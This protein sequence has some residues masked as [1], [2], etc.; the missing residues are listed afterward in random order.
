MKA[1][2]VP[3]VTG[4][5]T[6]VWIAEQRLGRSPLCW[7]GRKEQSRQRVQGVAGQSWVCSADGHTGALEAEESG[8]V[9][10]C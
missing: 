1:W 10:A 3:F 4:S 5:L 7:E 8:Q 9:E 2:E 6:E